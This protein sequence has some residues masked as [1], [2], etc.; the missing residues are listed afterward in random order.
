MIKNSIK[1][2]LIIS[3]LILSA[4]S[5]VGS[6]A[7]AIS[8]PSLGAAGSFGA[9]ASQAMT[10]TGLT[11]ITADSGNADIG[12]SALA[13]TSITGFN[14]SG[15][16][17]G[18]EYGTDSVPNVAATA[19]A[20][21]ATAYGTLAG[22]TCTNT[23]PWNPTTGQLAGLTLVPGVYCSGSSIDLATV[24]TLTL[25]GPG[26]Y[27]FH[28]VSSLTTNPD[29]TI[30]LTNG[31]TADNVFWVAGS[32]ATIARGATVNEN[33]PGT[34]IAQ[35]AVTVSGST[36]PLAN[37][38]TIH[39]R[40]ISLTAAVTFA[41][42]TTVTVPST[43]APVTLS[44]IA[45]TT[46]A[47][48]LSYTVGDTLDISGL[49][50]TGTFSDTS[51]S[52]V[53][54]SVTG[55]DSSVPVTGQVLT[56][57]VGSQT[58]TYTINVVAAPP[59]TLNLGTASDYAILSGNSAGVITNGVTGQ[60]ISRGNVGHTST[61][62]HPFTFASGFSDVSNSI[63]L[64][65]ITTGGT[66][67]G[68]AHA[69]LVSIGTY[70]GVTTGLAC[71][72]ILPP[73][74]DLAADV[75][76]GTLGHYSPGVYCVNGAASIGT[77]GITLNGVGTYVFKINGVL[78]D[79]S[80]STVSLTGGALPSNLFWVP[81]GGASLFGSD[82]FSGTVL[83]GPA[84]ITTGAVTNAANARFISES[85]ITIG[86][87]PNVFSIPSA[88]DTTN[89]TVSISSSIA[90]SVINQS[91]FAISGTASDN[92]LVDH[93]TVTVDG[94][95][96]TVTGTSTW[97]TDSGTLS[98]GIH[99]IT[100]TS[101]DAA[102]N[103]ATQS[104]HVTMNTVV[105]NTQDTSITSTTGA[106]QVRSVTDAGNFVSFTP[107][108]ESTLPLVGKPAV[109][110]PYGFLSFHITGLTIGQTIH[111]TQTYP[112]ILPTGTKYW[113]IESGV[114]TDATSLI[115]INRNTLT[116]T[117]T[118]GGFGDSDGLANGMI[119]DPSGISVPTSATIDLGTAGTFG[120][121]AS[122]YTNTAAAVVI[123]G[124]L[125]YT[126]GSAVVPTIFGSTYVAPGGVYS[127]AGTDQG[128]ALVALN[129]LACD[130]TFGSA[131]VLSALPQPL[132]P[133]V[134]CVTGAQSIGTAGITLSSAGNYVF[135]ST[136]ALDTVA[137]SH[138]T[139]SGLADASHVFWTPGAA[140]TLGANSV[141]VG[142]DI[143]DSGITIGDTV[144]WLGR[145]LDFATT[146]STGPSVTITVPP[147][148]PITLLQFHT[149]GSPTSSRYHPS[150]GGTEGLLF[151]DGLK[152]NGNVFD[153]SKYHTSI[154]Q[155]VLPLDKP[156]TITIKQGF[157]RASPFWQHVMVF[158]NFNGKDTMSGNADTWI[159]VDKTDGVQV[160]DPNGFVT[161]VSV[162]NNFTAYGMT[163]TFAFTPVKQMSDSNMVIRVWDDQLRQTDAYVDGAI[164]LG[165]APTPAKPMQKP[166]WLQ[167]FSNLKDADNAV[168]SAGFVKPILFAHI[169]TTNQIWIEPKM[170]GNVLWFFDTKD[171][172]VAVIIYDNKGNML[173]EHA[174][175]LVKVSTTLTGKDASHAGNHL[176]SRNVDEINQA[177]IQQE[178][179]AIQTMT[180]LGY[181]Q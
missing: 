144:T 96:V 33:F 86:G 64:G 85:A 126:T 151:S 139:L 51:T 164:L 168:E 167:V 108:N 11:V 93:V 104:I 4:S 181:H 150:L 121:L 71:N 99:A 154:Q 74:V 67:I 91:H 39:G 36:N 146:V 45:I 24:S 142:T 149:S 130:F 54:P 107:V 136:G 145:A 19:N 172:Q 103:S 20:D 18:T 178:L 78:T 101:F 155:Q 162:N 63:I 179:N 12:S 32:F 8:A 38:L 73:G 95:P 128:A 120:I 84:A 118:D 83:A 50:V 49:V 148:S 161:N 69:V 98:D 23:A 176:N 100:A 56:I 157:E 7:F 171:A 114:W 72:T 47:T 135:R 82:Q 153:I 42:A 97:S 55:F 166:D 14:P 102:G 16:F 66:P 140:T 57:H 125:G 173:D 81:V 129:A 123:H 62:T 68:D 92:V 132:A 94:T 152:I 1:S 17:T 137:G 180:R 22:T 34:V 106:G 131:T 170:G 119:S 113:K 27:I 112:T 105:I 21:A 77:A 124:D 165:D 169:S 122:T 31:A 30:V 37:A 5:M 43:V 58:K 76:H 177:K 60:F 80:G 89:P 28:A 159:S 143:D 88:P 117:I 65:T 61:E 52:V 44:S 3:V 175:Q 158:M 10:N 59:V 48:K 138:V 35:T 111:V 133:G 134:Y 2:Y 163:T 40:L 9:L 110:F 46:P 6:Q 116:L 15:T 29:T 26:V 53:T 90:G 147:T 70:N 141:F 87:G 13:T 75:T 41:A 79:V 115:S 25:D 156:A 174:E 127:Q 160:H 109:A